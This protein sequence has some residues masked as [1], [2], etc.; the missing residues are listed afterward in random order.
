LV[1]ALI[2]GVAAPAY[3]EINGDLIALNDRWQDVP[4]GPQLKLSIQITD[5]LTSIGNLIG[6]SMNDLTDDTI[7][8]KFDGRKRRA[9]LHVGT[10]DGQYLR[11]N[12]DSDWHFSD[13]KARIAAKLQLGIGDHQLNIDLPDMEMSPAEYHGDRGVELRVP[14]FERTW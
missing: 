3:A 4:A 5:E 2:V 8:L 9:Q 14:V 7:G 11:F 6:T 1:V 12:L 10:G 13:G